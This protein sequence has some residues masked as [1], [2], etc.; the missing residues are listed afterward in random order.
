MF[1]PVLKGTRVTLR[2]PTKD[3]LKHYMRW[4]ADPEVIRYLI[5]P[6]AFSESMEEAWFNRASEDPNSVAWCIEVDGKPVGTLGL[7]QIDWIHR[8]AVTGTTI[9]DKSY[10][11]QGIASEAMAL[12][13]RF[14][15]RELGLHKLNTA[16]YAENEA[17]RR[18]L[19][20]TGYRQ[21]GIKR[22]EHYRDGRFHDLWEG[23][24][25]REEWERGQAAGEGGKATADR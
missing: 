7:A 8:H 18:A 21:S 9:G 19:E 3:D 17:S 25:L 12:R 6:F 16:A 22:Q 1:G 23:E 4:F 10:W 20:K 14:A 15:F 5:R 24:L 2:P 13:T 11:R